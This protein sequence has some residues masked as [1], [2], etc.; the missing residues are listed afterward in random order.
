LNELLAE[1]ARE[2]GIAAIVIF[3]AAGEV[4]AASDAATAGGTI[5]E[6]PALDLLLPGKGVVTRYRQTPEGTKVFEIIRPFR[7]FAADAL[8]RSAESPERGIGVQPDPLRRWAGDKLIALN[9]GLAA[10]EAARREDRHHTL[11]MAAILLALGTGTLYFIFIVQNYYLVNRTL[12]RMRSYTEN[13]VES[14]ADGL[15]TVDREGRVVTANRQ[16]QAILGGE[17]E[18]LEGKPVVDVLGSAGEGLLLSEGERAA[19]RLRGRGRRRC[20]RC[21]PGHG[22]SVR[23]W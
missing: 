20:G 11:L 14:M 18:A 12:G 8:P 5:L 3:T 7:P 6:A 22:R 17:R 13:V 10:V 2:P 4:V 21:R 16:A 23:P 9:L 19:M 15:I 1:V